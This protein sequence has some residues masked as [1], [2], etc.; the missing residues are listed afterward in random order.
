VK[1]I[2]KAALPLGFQANGLACAIKRSGKPDLAL[3]YSESPAKAFGLFTTSKIISGSLKF[4]QINLK[5]SKHFQ[6][7]IV[8]SGNANC[9]T[10]EDS[11]NKAEEVASA[12]A[13]LLRIK[14]Q[15][16]LLASTGIIGRPFPVNRIKTALPILIRG[17]SESGLI[18]VSR[19]I[20]TTDTFIKLSSA[21]I[22]IGESLITICGLAK[23]AGM[24]APNLTLHHFSRNKGKGRK[25]AGAKA[26]MLCFILSDV[27]I[28]QKALRKALRE[29]VDNSFN[30][31]TVD[32]CMSTNDTLFL[33]S[34]SCA[35]NPLIEEGSRD[36]D[37]FSSVLGR[38]CLDLAKMI[39]RDAEGATKF[40]QIKVSQARTY[41]EAKQ[42]GLS[43]ANSN[44]FKAAMFGQSKNF[45]RVVAA[46]GASGINTK[47]RD[48]KIKV[49]PLNKKD[50]SLMVKL[51]R[52][53]CQAVVYTSDLT[54]EY[55][56]I[57]ADYS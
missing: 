34:N 27:N 32:G 5:R 24:I 14:K 54:P 19:A 13:R 9:F 51:K 2:I 8:N 40:I 31:I 28:T 38:I 43:I 30:C 45:G 37:R 52:G 48:L 47:E 35:N 53:N 23:G 17:L 16:V 21:R 11:F 56:K 20:M 1:K 36:F 4:S 42:V 29:A 6:A 12:L 49:S 7:I 26:T 15:E 18:S 22:K 57:N 44:L 33:M 10:K 46:I 41:Q 25:V 3:I 55:V 39:I 50:I